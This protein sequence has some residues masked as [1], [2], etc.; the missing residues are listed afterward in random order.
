MKILAS[1]GTAPSLKQRIG[2]VCTW[3]VAG[4]CHAPVLTVPK[5]SGAVSA[6]APEW[7][8]Q[9]T[10]W[11]GEFTPSTA[12]AQQGA[13]WTANSGATDKLYYPA[14]A[15]LDAVVTDLQATTVQATAPNN[16]LGEVG[17]N[18]ATGSSEYT[19]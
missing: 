11:S 2:D 5:A 13:T 9:I 17:F 3:V 18:L 12:D 6:T 8:I 14:L 1:A 19:Y 15:D 7:L 10:E 16:I 4:Q